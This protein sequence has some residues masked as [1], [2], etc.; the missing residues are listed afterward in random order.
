MNENCVRYLL[1]FELELELG[2]CINTC[3][4]LVFPKITVLIFCTNSIPRSFS[5][6]INFDHFYRLKS[7]LSYHFLANLQSDVKQMKSDIQEMKSEMKQVKT[8]IQE[9]QRVIQNQTKEIKD[10]MAKYLIKGK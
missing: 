7:I 2:K 10:M 4:F 3:I 6:L 5:L 9:N 8:E 1:W